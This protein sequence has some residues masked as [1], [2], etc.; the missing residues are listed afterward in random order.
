MAFNTRFSLAFKLLITLAIMWSVAGESYGQY[1]V[2]RSQEPIVEK[3]DEQIFLNPWAGGLNNAQL[4]SVQLNEDALP[5]LLVFEKTGNRWLPF[6]GEMFAGEFSYHYSPEWLGGLPGANVLGLVL[7]YDGDS[8]PDILTYNGLALTA[9]RCLLQEEGVWAFEPYQKGNALKTV[10]SGIKQ[11]LRMTGGD[12]PGVT[13]LDGDG[14]LDILVVDGSGAFVE[15]HANQS[16]ELFGHADSL[17]FLLNSDCWGRFRENPSNDGITL[18]TCLS[19]FAPERIAARPA[20][21]SKNEGQG[22]QIEHLF[23]IKSD[24][25]KPIPMDQI[26]HLFSENPIY[27]KPIHTGSS[28][29]LSDIDG[30]GILDLLIG[31]NGGSRLGWLQNGGDNA[32]ADMIFHEPDWPSED[33]PVLAPL[34]PAAF[35]LDANGDGRKD[36]AISAQDRG[37]SGNFDHLLLYL[38][39]AQGLTPHFVLSQSGFLQDDMLDF[40]EGACPALLDADGDGDLDIVVG[41]AGYRDL[42]GDPEARLA[43][44]E[45]KGGS[46]IRFQLTQ[47]DFAG[48]SAIPTITCCAC[49]TFT[50]LD[51]DGDQDMLTGM[52]DGQLAFFV[53]TAAPGNP[54]AFIFVENSFQN[55]DVGSFAM[56][57]AIDINRDGLADLVIGERNGNVN[58]YQNTGSSTSPAFSLQQEIWGGISVTDG[59][60]LSVGFSAPFAFENDHGGI[61]LL[62]GSLGGKVF[63]YRDVFESGPDE[64][65]VADSSFAG[66]PDGER[67]SPIFADLDGDGFRD[68]ILGN[69]SGGLQ[70]FKGEAGST[71]L[72]ESPFLPG[73]QQQS[74]IR[75]FPNPSDGCFSIALPTQLSANHMPLEAGAISSIQIRNPLG[76]LVW[77]AFTRELEREWCLD[78]EPGLYWVVVPGYRPGR[79]MVL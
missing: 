59:G 17:T 9:W 73:A 70:Y 2:S 32:D 24:H 52:D 69:F 44:L 38:D 62:V 26:E 54:A 5:D 10:R 13:D 23:N 36:I 27:G 1:A 29:C 58:Y 53:N 67:V 22:Q 12:I 11:D 75:I 51:G 68:L 3:P 7:D 19:P 71:G 30:D 55:I 64:F 39:T 21:D 15:W 72:E 4:S 34:F 42:S 43:L 20:E 63:F 14:D 78:L 8:D 79:F 50:D 41:N 37:F 16:F 49:P 18:D 60:L 47:T 6:I 74:A 65:Q 31:D 40:G 45:N 28:L 77:N 76:E 25:P 56:P 46:P 57:F 33:I 66:L 35:V 48:L 61:D